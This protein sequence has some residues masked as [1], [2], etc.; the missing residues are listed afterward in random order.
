MD[1]D[2]GSPRRVL[3]GDVKPYAV[4]ER[5]EQLAGPASGT[6]VL[7]HAVLW[8]GDG[9]VDLDE[10]GGTSLAYRAV[11]SEGTVADQVSI[12]HHARLLAVWPDLMLPLRVRQLWERRFPELADAAVA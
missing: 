3:V 12:L 4:P 10:P 11:I 6:V 2:D 1:A 7:P 9:L 5:L 8:V